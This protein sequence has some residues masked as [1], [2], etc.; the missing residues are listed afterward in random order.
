MPGK[1]LVVDDEPDLELL[2]RQKFR[3]QIRDKEFEFVFARN[4]VDALEKLQTD[5]Q[6]D[7]VLADINM[8]EMDGLTLVEKLDD[9]NPI[10][11]AVIIS[12]YGDMANIRG[13][14]NRGAYDFITKPIDFQDLEITINRTLHHVQQYLQQVA[15][16]TDAAAAIE[17]GEFDVASLDVVA[18]CGGELGRLGR[19]FQQMA[20]EVYAREQRLKQEVQ[21]L[22]IKI[23]EARK[24]RLVAE[25][26]E[27]DYFRRLQQRAH[28]LRSRAAEQAGEGEQT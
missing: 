28:A 17:A 18:E 22:R 26:T 4:G 15:R 3:K 23:D 25:V 2:I 8:P 13:A 21:E 12:A 19:V 6:I 10:L 20:R 7:L 16:L 24:A 27:S 9:L 5:P 14:M 11:R 1:I